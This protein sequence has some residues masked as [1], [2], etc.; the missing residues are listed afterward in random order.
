MALCQPFTQGHK[1][2]FSISFYDR[3]SHKEVREAVYAERWLRWTYGTVT[4]RAASWVALRRIWFSVLAGKWMNTRASARKIPAF[5]ERYG[6]D[7]NQFDVP[8]DGWNSFNEFFSRKVRPVARPVNTGERT[9]VLPADGRHL[10]YADGAD[11]SGLVVKG[12]PFTLVELLGDVAL[13]QRFEGGALVVSRLCP[14]DYHRFH[15]PLAGVPG[16]VTKL[17]GPLDSVSP[18]ALAAGARS[19]AANKREVTI[20]QTPIAGDVA[21]VEV[22]A[23]CVGRIVQSFLP[24]STVNK[25]DE[26]GYFL[27]GGSTV[28]TV[29]QP[30]CVDLA[31]DLLNH[32]ARGMETYAR[33]GDAMGQIKPTVSI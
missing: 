13:A 23:A 11:L 27:F 4:G 1:N 16:V 29:F 19:L 15:F 14:T 3:Y 33:M 10:A 32:S 18:I 12:R 17:P 28:I 6:I 7:M 22:G 9:V 26:K 5:V 30:G 31:P 21:L 2:L 8:D 24:G 20:L 25:G